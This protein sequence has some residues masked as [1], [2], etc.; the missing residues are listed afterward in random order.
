LEWRLP[1]TF[2]CGEALMPINLNLSTKEQ[3][4]W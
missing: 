1:L 4:D 3:R 2:A